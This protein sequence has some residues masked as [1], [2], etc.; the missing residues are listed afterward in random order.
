MSP[1]LHAHV[2]ETCEPYETY[3]NGNPDFHVFQTCDWVEYS[4]VIG[5]NGIYCRAL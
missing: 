5:L 2:I 3:D 1:H 4:Q